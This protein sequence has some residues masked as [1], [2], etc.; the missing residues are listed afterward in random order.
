[1]DDILL[2][3]NSTH[4]SIQMSL[5]DFKALHPKLQFTSEEGKDQN[6]NCLDISI[7][8]THTNIKTAIYRK[9][10]FTDTIIPYTFNHPTNHKCNSQ[11]PIQ[12]TR[13]LQPKT[14]RIPP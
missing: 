13:F 14:R 12:Q 6:L 11:I 2:I 4:T 10:T 5:V 3:Y 7:H 9:P 8:R 1:V